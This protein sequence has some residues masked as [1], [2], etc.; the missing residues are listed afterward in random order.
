MLGNSEMLAEHVLH[1]MRRLMRMVDRQGFRAGIE[2]GD[3][4][5][6]LK[7]KSGLAVETEFLFDDNCGFAEGSIGIAGL[8][9]VLEGKVVAEFGMDHRRFGIECDI[10][11]DDGG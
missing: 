9:I 6:W 10:A 7:G 4:A 11:I 5:A 3:Q 1:L 8:D 2:I